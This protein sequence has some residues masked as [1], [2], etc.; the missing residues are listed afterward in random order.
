MIA[1][2]EDPDE[3]LNFHAHDGLFDL[4]LYVPFS[5]M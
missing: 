4:I 2:S 5:V 1:N 3:M